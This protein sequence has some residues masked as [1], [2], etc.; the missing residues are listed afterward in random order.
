M[1]TGLILGRLRTREWRTIVTDEHDHRV[2]SE[3]AIIELVEE[4]AHKRVKPVH[5]G[6]IVGDPDESVLD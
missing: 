5:T 6:I 3:S 4:D 2:F 1:G